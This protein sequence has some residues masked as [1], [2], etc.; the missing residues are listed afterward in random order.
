MSIRRL[1]ST[2]LG[3]QRERLGVNVPA[4]VEAPTGGLNTRDNEANMPIGDALICT[5]II[6]Q[7]GRMESRKGYI[8]F[9]TNL[10]GN[11]ETISQYY[12]GT[13][14]KIIAAAGGNIYDAS[15]GGD[16]SSSILGSGFNESRWQTTNFRGTLVMV[17][18]N[19]APQGY[20]GSSLSPLTIS[21]SGL[22]VSTLV[23]VTAHKNRL[24]WWDG[25]TQEV[26]YGAVDTIGGTLTK[27][28]LDRVGQFGG[29]LV[30]AATWSIDGG[31]GIDDY[32]VFFM[33]GGD[34][35]VYQGEDP[36]SDF[37]LIG[38]YRL[39]SP[40]SIRAVSELGGDIA[41]VNQ[42][43]LVF[44][45]EV[46]KNGGVVTNLSKL[47]GA[48]QSAVQTYG[49]N[50]GWEIK[51]YAKGGW[52]MVNVPET[53]NSRYAQYVINSINGSPWKIEGWNARTFEV[54]DEELYFG[55]DSTIYK[56]DSGFI[57]GTDGITVDVQQAFSNLGESRPKTINYYRPV[58]ETTG[59]IDI[60]FN[61]YFDFDQTP[62]TQVVNVQGVGAPWD[63]SPWDT[64]AW[65]PQ[66]LIKTTQYFA[67]GQGRY[68]SIGFTTTL[69]GQELKWYNT[70]Y[71]LTINRL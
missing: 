43:D 54:Y 66:N 35:L 16:V 1:R 38:T 61:V 24:W 30:A 67:S 56:A 18:G 36:G 48:I 20:D 21:G 22:T 62:L 68:L 9:A 42:N 33:S 15:G 5:N 17:S 23:G 70:D 34:I 50:Y 64:T 39:S 26:W 27:F 10:N 3:L 6:P 8:T 60:N 32:I 71:S 55:G 2:Y 11:V 29:H 44:F 45:S 63:T 28:P 52:L 13:N 12:S 4:S 58:I 65:S 57:D 47:S 31:A 25:S 14:R 59:E 51:Y 19:D 53:T 37:A 49:T 69:K 40:I 41:L 7:L 46:F